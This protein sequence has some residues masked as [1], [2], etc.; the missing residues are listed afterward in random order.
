VASPAP[1]VRAAISQSGFD[2]NIRTEIR[3]E[4]RTRKPDPKSDDSFEWE[5]YGFTHAGIRAEIH[6]E[7]A[8]SF[9]RSASARL[10][11]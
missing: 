5:E 3:T 7:I 6:A 8:K 1:F 2:M 9:S 4:I 10:P 11:P